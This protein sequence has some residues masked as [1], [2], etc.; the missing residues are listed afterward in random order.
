MVKLHGATQDFEHGMLN[1]ELLLTIIEG[2]SESEVNG[3]VSGLVAGNQFVFVILLNSC[4][5]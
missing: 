1:C 5:T 4:C 3:V 2:V